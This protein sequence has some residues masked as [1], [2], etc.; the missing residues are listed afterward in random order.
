MKQALKRADCNHPR[1]ICDVFKSPLLAMVFMEK[2]WTDMR[3]KRT[4]VTFV[5]HAPFQLYY[6][7]FTGKVRKKRLWIDNILVRDL[8]R[9][10][11]GKLKY[12]EDVHRNWQC[13][14]LCSL[15]DIWT[16]VQSDRDLNVPKSSV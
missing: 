4:K 9:V 14:R 7:F 15:T 2:V 13:K 16:G 1:Q 12:L 10:D 8:S 3:S 5:L 6:Y 11:N